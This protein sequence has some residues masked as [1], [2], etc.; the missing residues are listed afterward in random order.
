LEQQLMTKDASIF[1]LTMNTDEI[2]LR[3]P[4]G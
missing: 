2:R 3:P 1:V 4:V